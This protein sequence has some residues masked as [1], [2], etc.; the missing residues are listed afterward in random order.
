[1][2]ASNQSEDSGS[3]IWTPIAIGLAI[4]A[5]VGGSTWWLARRYGW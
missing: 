3:S 5:L 2:P 4:A 1:M